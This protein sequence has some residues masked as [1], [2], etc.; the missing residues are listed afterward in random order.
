MDKDEILERFGLLDKDGFSIGTTRIFDLGNDLINEIIQLENEKIQELGRYISPQNQALYNQISNKFSTY[1]EF[2]TSKI[3]INDPNNKLYKRD[4][5]GYFEYMRDE[6]PPLASFFLD[7]FEPYFSDRVRACHTY[8][9]GASSSGKSELM[10]SII[11]GHILRNNCSVVLIE[12][13]GDLAKQIYKSKIF[14][15]KPQADRLIIIEP[16]FD[17]HLTPIINIFDQFTIKN[18]FD[19]DRISQ[20]YTKTFA[21]IFEDLGEVPTGRM[22]TI[23]GHCITVIL[24]KKDS[25]I[26]D[27]LRFMTNTDNADLID[28]GT[29]DHNQT[30][31]DFFRNEF[32][33]ETYKHT[34]N[35]IYDRLQG[36]LKNQ[37]FAGLTTGKSTVNVT[38]SINSNKV[39][40]LNLSRGGIGTEV[41]QAFG[42]LI[43]SI[44]Q[45][46]GLQR[47][48]IKPENRPI[49][50]LFIDEFQNYIS[51]T[52]KEILEE[53]RKYKVFI[54][55]AN[56]YVGQDLNTN[57]VKSILGNTKIKVIGQSSYGNSTNM[58][59]EMQIKPE[60]ITDLNR[61]EFY[62]QYPNVKTGKQQTIKIT[63]TKKYL[64]EDFCM[65]NTAYNQLK[66]A[67]IERFY[68]ERVN[69]TPDT[70][71]R[72]QNE[73]KVPNKDG[74]NKSKP[75]YNEPSPILDLDL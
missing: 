44:V 21:T 63:G 37:I 36:L 66:I 33:N 45:I 20:E 47:D 69:H 39:L 24:R 68:V 60:Q 61:G 40:I 73:N 6:N 32:E 34:K 9:T 10:K 62:I 18:E 13:H 38:N 72:P 35:G 55:L 26:K 71:K 14:L 42:R 46:T 64:G 50:H 19:L 65:E 5:D 23:L 15:D 8:I 57:E 22:K 3:P 11:I 41:S 7:Y 48:E 59:R 49:T 53:L 31:A 30:T 58:A 27:L 67:Q 70:T 16:N 75:K 74:F 56:Q 43:I 4:L 54:T 2:I 51:D 28:L 52:I 17:H 25:S 29:K 1:E 12:P